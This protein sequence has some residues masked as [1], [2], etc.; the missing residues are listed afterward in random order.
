M[1]DWYKITW[2]EGRMEA[3]KQFPD[4][5]RAKHFARE[6][7]RRGFDLVTLWHCIGTNRQVR[8]VI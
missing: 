4:E 5:E 8:I 6:K 1:A 7:L 2:R 3:S